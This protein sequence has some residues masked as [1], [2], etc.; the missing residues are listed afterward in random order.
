VYFVVRYEVSEVVKHI[1]YSNLGVR[2][3][4][5]D[6]IVG[7]VSWTVSGAA[8]SALAIVSIWTYLWQFS[9]VVVG[10]YVLSLVLVMARTYS[11]IHVEVQP[12]PQKVYS[13]PKPSAADE[14]AERPLPKPVYGVVR[15]AP[16]N[17]QL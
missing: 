14:E 8:L 6:T 17:T 3:E 11:K 9:L 13:F 5:R 2:S 1:N 4:S 16:R 15:T 12:A 7:L 10:A